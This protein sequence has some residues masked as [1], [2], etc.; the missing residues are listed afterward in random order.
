M[1]AISVSSGVVDCD[2]LQANSTDISLLR[3]EMKKLMDRY[4][5][6]GADRLR[7]VKEQVENVKGIMRENIGTLTTSS[8]NTRLLLS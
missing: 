7:T 4:S 6:P 1:H 8:F 5:Q 2:R 3:A